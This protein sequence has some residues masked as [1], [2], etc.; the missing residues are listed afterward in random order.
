MCVQPPQSAMKAHAD[1]FGKDRPALEFC[2]QHSDGAATGGDGTYTRPP[3]CVRSC[4]GSAAPPF[5]SRNARSPR[6]AEGSWCCS[7]SPTR[8]TTQQPTEHAEPLYE[9]FCERAGAKR[10]VFGAHMDIELVNDGPVTLML[11]T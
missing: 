6:S 8:T 3:P 10:G 4:R 9:R 2:G 5:G 7:G 11:E 1:V